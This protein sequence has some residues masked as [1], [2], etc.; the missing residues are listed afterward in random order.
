MLLQDF[1]FP[2]PEKLIAQQP[3]VPRDS[4]R[5]FVY[6]RAKDTIEH[7][8][9]RDLPELLPAHTML[10]GNN[11]KVRKAR[12]KAMAYIPGKASRPTMEI[13][14]LEKL[15]NREYRCMIGGKGVIKDSRLVILD[16]NGKPTAVSALVRAREEHPGMN[17]YRVVLTT[18]DL[19]QLLEAYGSMPL[20]PYITNPKSTDEQYQTVFAR[21]LGSAAAPTAGLHFTPELLEKLEKQGHLWREVTLHVGMGTFLPLRNEEVTENTLHSEQTSIEEPVAK[22]LSEQRER[23]QPILAVGTTATRTL[24]SH[25]QDGRIQAGELATDMF[26]YPGY[27]FQTVTH[28]LTNFHLPKSSLLLLVAAFLGNTPDHQVTKNEGEMTALLQ[29]LY[30][31][32]IRQQYRF[33]SFG[34]AML[35]L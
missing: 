21:E 23:H 1:S 22:E 14:V 16:H 9:V 4:A 7:R 20:P 33:F 19:D 17:T 5:L 26:I 15:A 32:A 31:E 29:R 28:L 3:A 12:L 24:E 8:H 30:A 10:V 35:I 11:S 13:L 25:S 2:L 6:D 27:Q 34:D 18:A